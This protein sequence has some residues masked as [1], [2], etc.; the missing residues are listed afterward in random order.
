MDDDDLR[1]PAAGG[2]V[3]FLLCMVP[4]LEINGFGFGLPISVPAAFVCSTIGGVLAG[5]LIC[6]RPII[7]GIVGGV[8]AGPLGLRLLLFYT[9]HRTH[10]WNLEIL[11]VTAVGS[12][13]GLAVGYVLKTLIGP[14]TRKKKRRKKK[15]S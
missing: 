10:L 5:G 13:P 14:G 9:S 4:A 1:L 11:L 15:A 12:L 3:F 2:M 7:A 6:S 8:I